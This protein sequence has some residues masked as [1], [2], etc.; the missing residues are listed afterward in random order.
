MGVPVLR[1]RKAIARRRAEPWTQHL[2]QESDLAPHNRAEAI[3]GRE[4]QP[5]RRV[6][7]IRRQPAMSP[8][9]RKT[10]GLD[11]HQPTE[12]PPVLCSP[13][14]RGEL[15]SADQSWR[16]DRPDASEVEERGDLDAVDKDV[17]LGGGR[18]PDDE[19]G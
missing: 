15:Q 13:C 16:D 12:R 5:R 4:G 19:I 3:R 9:V 8:A 1:Q 18:T 6:A 7:R 14:T 11:L 2:I 17:R 10:L